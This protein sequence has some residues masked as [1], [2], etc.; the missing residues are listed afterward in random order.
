VA[1]VQHLGSKRR[2][3]LPS[4]SWPS[5]KVDVMEI[6]GIVHNG[7]IVPDDDGVV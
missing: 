5:R 1:Y 3:N 6:E 7:V 2:Y 4:E